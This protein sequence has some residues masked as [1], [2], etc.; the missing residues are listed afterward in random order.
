MT[1]LEKARQLYPEMPEGRIIRCGCPDALPKIRITLH[2]LM[3]GCECLPQECVPCWMQ[4]AEKER[5]AMQP[6]DT[7]NRPVSTCAASFARR[8]MPD[9]QTVD[10]NGSSPAEAG[11]NGILRQTRS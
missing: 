6:S 8:E 4:A 7:R 3:L 9:D 1:Y 5:K 10:K 2:C 11:V